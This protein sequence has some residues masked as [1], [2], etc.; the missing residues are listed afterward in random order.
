MKGFARTVP[1]LLA[2]RSAGEEIGALAAIPD[3]HFHVAGQR[4]ADREQVRHLLSC[5]TDRE[6][7]V[8][9]AHYGIGR[10]RIPAT[11]DEV[12]Q[13]LGISRHASARS[14]A[15][16]LPSS[17]LP[18]PARIPVT[19]PTSRTC[20]RNL[21]MTTPASPKP[22]GANQSGD[23]RDQPK[24]HEAMRT[25]LLTQKDHTGSFEAV[26]RENRRKDIY[27]R[28]ADGKYPNAIQIRAERRNTTSCLK[29]SAAGKSSTSGRFRRRMW[30]R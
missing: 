23:E 17:D 6:R 12:G 11:Y 16:P 20:C 3:P 25:I 13:S 5:L 10:A 22:A 8:L 19:A 29:E 15:L 18:Q 30:R 28:P 26:S 4:L 21:E 14:N 24:L 7:R 2:S 9:L 27:R 1:E